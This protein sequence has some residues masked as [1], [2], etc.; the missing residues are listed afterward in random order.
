MLELYPALMCGKRI[1]P[2]HSAVLPVLA[3][4]CVILNITLEALYVS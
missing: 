1:T 3:R 4:P 2:H